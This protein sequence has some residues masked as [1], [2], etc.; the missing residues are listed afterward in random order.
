MLKTKKKNSLTNYE[1][2]ILVDQYLKT[3]DFN[4]WIKNCGYP[5]IG[6]FP[7]L[8]NKTINLNKEEYSIRYEEKKLINSELIPINCFYS[9]IEFTI[10]KDDKRIKIQAF[11]TIK[12]IFY[13]NNKF[14]SIRFSNIYNHIDLK[15]SIITFFTQLKQ[16]IFNSNPTTYNDITKLVELGDFLKK[17]NYIIIFDAIESISILR[18]CQKNKN[19]TSE[20]ESEFCFFDELPLSQYCY[21]GEFI[22]L[23][24]LGKYFFKFHEQYANKVYKLYKKAS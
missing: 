11:Y 14:L 6:T 2:D 18:I 13:S 16:E 3:D 21:D 12:D 23:N 8:F 1:F 19:L 15:E 7:E 17:Q 20:S 10:I 4:S 22:Y 9:Q 5:N 24:I